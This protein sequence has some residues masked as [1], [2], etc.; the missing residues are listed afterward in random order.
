VFCK[1]ISVSGSFPFPLDDEVFRRILQISI[2]ESG[3][4]GRFHD[5]IRRNQNELAW[6]SNIFFNP[7]RRPCGRDLHRLATRARDKRCPFYGEIYVLTAAIALE[8]VPLPPLLDVLVVCRKRGYV[9][10][11]QSI[12]AHLECLVLTKGQLRDSSGRCRMRTS[13]HCFLSQLKLMLY[14]RC[15]PPPLSR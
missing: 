1:Y 6:L 13:Y 9:A 2:L 10:Y 11:H 4:F 8:A 3:N 14:H 7:V 5:Q 12:F 15:V